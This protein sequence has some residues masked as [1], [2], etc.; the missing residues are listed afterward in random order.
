MTLLCC[1]TFQLLA[2]GFNPGTVYL[3]DNGYVEYLAGNLP[4]VISVPHGGYVEPDD[5]PDRNCT[6]CVYLRDSYT[7]E[8]A[9]LIQASFY[10]ETG[11]Y[12][13][14]VINLLHRRKFDANRDIDTAADGDASVEQS[15]YAYHDFLDTA[16]VAIAQSYSR[17]LFLDLHGHAHDIQRVELGYLLSRSELQLVDESLNMEEYISESS[18]QSLV[19]DNLGGH[20]HAELLR[21]PTSLG[22]LLEG[23]GFA[24]V[25]SLD[26]PFPED[27]EPYF[28]GGY[29]TRRHSSLEGG[30]IDGIQI[31]CN[32]NIRFEEDLREAFADSLTQSV[33]RYIDTHFNEEFT[34]NYCGLLSQSTS[35]F[36]ADPIMVYPNPVGHQFQLKSNT[37]G[38]DIMI[39]NS[40]G[41]PIKQLQWNGA[42]INVGDLSNGVYFLTFSQEGELLGQDVLVKG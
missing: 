26:T 10:E 38:V 32:R 1:C 11:C 9:W 13:H 19:S 18:I 5:I 27:D 17:G 40:L 20:S 35:V 6:G 22:T 12:P 7:Q 14:L 30:M 4:I 37:G 29:N 39:Y 25:P 16:K 31:E 21:G 41:Q 33:I 23:Q 24:A 3:D 2:Q 42:P 28:T 34:G 36:D 8:M 15:W